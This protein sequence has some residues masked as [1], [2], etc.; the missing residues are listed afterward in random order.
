MCT[1][2]SGKCGKEAKKLQKFED[3]ENEKILDNKKNY[4][5]LIPV[6]GKQ[7]FGKIQNFFEI[8][9]AKSTIKLKTK[10]F[11][12]FRKVNPKF[13]ILRNICYLYLFF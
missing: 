9:F 8:F 7:I 1:F 6:V 5:K 10:Y 12:G 4:Q 11:I 3:L 2:E 13:S